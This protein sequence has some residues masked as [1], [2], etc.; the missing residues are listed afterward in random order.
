MSLRERCGVLIFPALSILFLGC[1]FCLFRICIRS[2][3]IFFREIQVNAL[4]TIFIQCFYY[5]TD[6]V[7]CADFI[8][9]FWQTVEMF[10]YESS[11]R[12]IIFR[13]KFYI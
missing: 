2:G 4:D 1:C 3:V 12:I 5:E 8:P 7:L 13:I 10:N 6:A 9:N 11:E